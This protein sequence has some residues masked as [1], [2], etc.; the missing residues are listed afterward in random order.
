MLEFAAG[1][2]AAAPFDFG[3][4]PAEPAK[5]DAP[6]AA[7][8]AAPTGSTPT[9]CKSCGKEMTDP[10]D[11]AL[12]TCDECRTAAQESAPVPDTG[13]GRVEHVAASSIH[14]RLDPSDEATQPSAVPAPQPTLPTSISATLPSKGVKSAMRADVEPSGRGRYVAGGLIAIALVSAAIFLGV[15]KPWVS[16]APALVSRPQEQRQPVDTVIQQWK[17]NYPELSGES[18]KQAKGY[19]EEGESL[20]LKD[21]TAAYLDAEE[22]FQKALVLDPTM[23][24]AIAGW[25]LSIAFG[26]G[27]QIDEPTARAAESLLAGAERRGAE[28]RVFVAHAHLLIVR[29]GNP[30]DIKVLADRGQSSS[31]PSDRAL[32][33]LAIG[34]TFLTKNPQLA[35]ENFRDSLKL[36]AKIK[37]GYFFQAQ[38]ALSQGRYKDAAAALERRLE[39]DKDQWEAAE[40]LARIYVDVG[41]LAKARKV[42]ENARAASPTA[43]RPRLDLAMFDYQTGGESARAQEQLTALV[44]DQSIPRAERGDGYVHLAIIAHIAG[45]ATRAEDAIEKALE[46]N[47]GSIPARLQKFLLLVDRNVTSSARLELDALKGKLNDSALEAVLEGRL[48]LAENHPEEAA[49]LLAATWESTPRRVDALLLG[50]AAA[51]RARKEGRAWELCLKKGL[52]ADPRVTPIPPL[53]HLYVRPADLLKA[54]VG[55]YEAL[56][57]NSDEDPNPALCEGLVAWFSGDLT[58]AD[59]A[60]TR[61]NSIDPRSADAYAYRAYVAL[62]RR[63]VGG[64]NKLLARGLDSSKLSGNVYLG[65]AL[66]A[67]QL[68]KPDTE[69]TAAHDALR[70]NPALLSAKT[71]LGEAEA[72]LGDAVSARQGLTTVLLADPLFRD[73]KRVLYKQGL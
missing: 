67:A 13:A 12:G 16:R 37:R 36:D 15:R 65:Q 40:E 5:A 14:A 68:N 71:L 41:E 58:A 42:L 23:D 50:G 57:P 64:A 18:S 21:T 61:V 31:D 35:D 43:G 11:Q 10:F 52:R 70:Q 62:L 3:S 47:A 27:A 25:V 30:N 39:L 24:R 7:A 72:K 28:P 26:R 44:N 1:A 33:A 19:L 49:K 63:D 51:A 2:S 9:R 20:L 53:T 34:H 55:A 48:L 32:A 73:A 6:L 22:E 60:F 4:A 69:K 38:L 45:D 59:R 66:L 46:S 17:L 54:A 8:S 29:N 56:S